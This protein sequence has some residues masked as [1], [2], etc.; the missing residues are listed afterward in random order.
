MF[1]S[2]PTRFTRDADSRARVLDRRAGLSSIAALLGALAWVLVLT[3]SY[4]ARAD[5]AVWLESRGSLPGFAQVGDIVEIDLEMAFDETTIGGGFQLDYD[6]AIFELIDFAFS[7]RGLGDDP[8]YRCEPGVQVCTPR[9]GAH[10]V[11][12]GFG[13]FDGITGGRPVG[14]LRLRA[15]AQG[16]STIDFLPHPTTG[17]FV[18]L[19]GEPLETTSTGLNIRIVPEPATSMMIVIGCYALA[20]LPAR[21]H[22]TV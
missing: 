13:H 17:D 3:A 18:D 9:G 1:Q 7:N 16:E 10:L 14:R 20:S 4:S 6:P 8:R 21:R 22:S 12:I 11:P 19:A 2:I 15:L 5:N